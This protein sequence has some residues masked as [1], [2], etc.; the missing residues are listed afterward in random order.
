VEGTPG[1]RYAQLDSESCYAEVT[2]R[3]LPLRREGQSWPGV[4]APMRFT[5]PINGVLIHTDRI[6]SERASSP[7]ELFD[8]RLA[9][10]MDDFSKLLSA[11]GISEVV[12]FSAYRPPPKS[13]HADAEQLKR[14]AGGLAVDI[15]R[16]R[17][18]DGSWIKI[19]SDFHGRI[20]AKI[21]GVSAAPPNPSTPEAKLLR[22]VVCAAAEQH[23]FQLV[24]TPNYDRAHR[25][26]LHLGLTAEVKWF[27]VS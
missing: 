9:L 23:L 2:K 12:I 5:G 13:A 1:Y 15:H 4:T 18:A 14:H 17:R 26:H 22:R 20:G 21:C 25:N 24:L 16:L 8:C 3:Q 10:A 27:I 11:E 19:D 6:E 7:Y